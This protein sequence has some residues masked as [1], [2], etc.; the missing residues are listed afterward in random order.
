[1]SAPS[2]TSDLGLLAAE[3][4]DMR[5]PLLP[6]LCRLISPGWFVG[7]DRGNERTDPVITAQHSVNMV[8]PYVKCKMLAVDQCLPFSIK[9]VH[10]QMP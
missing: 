10:T 3:L 8:F 5:L 4:V 2:V 7:V 6:R 9:V 1:M